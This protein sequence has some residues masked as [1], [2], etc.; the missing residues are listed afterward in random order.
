MTRL[1]AFVVL[2][3]G[4]AAANP[5]KDSL[6]DAAESL[7]DAMSAARRAGGSCA[8]A[9]SN[10]LRKGVDDIDSIRWGTTELRFNEV[11]G[12][13]NTLAASAARAGCSQKVSERM[14]RAVM[15][16]NSAHAKLE[17]NQERRERRERR[18][19]DDDTDGHNRRPPTSQPTP[20]ARDCGIPNDAGCQMQRQ[21]QWAMDRDVFGGFFES[22]KNTN[23]DLSRADMCKAVFRSNWVTAKQVGLVLELFN[24]D[25]TRLDVAKYAAPHTVNPQQALGLASKFGSSLLQTDFT[26]L[27]SEQR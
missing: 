10:G 20:I 19:D 15:A 9:L 4:L 12:Y 5:Y 25:L 7:E 23:S 3:P 21:G 1:L 2:L 27:M 14:G 8:S 17:S 26:K 18:D 11:Q 6:T 13:V 16:L 22:L 24:S